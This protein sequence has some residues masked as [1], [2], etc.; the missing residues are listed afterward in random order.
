[1]ASH[2]VLAHR[3]Y[4]PIVADLKC[5]LNIEGVPQRFLKACFTE[6]TKILVM[7]QVC[8]VAF[9]YVVFCP[10][11]KRIGA[12]GCVK[13]CGGGDDAA[14]TSRSLLHAPFGFF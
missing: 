11:P 3:R 13:L 12:Y 1:M 2:S 4:N 10:L 9:D 8:F 7:V 14:V 6:W 5:V